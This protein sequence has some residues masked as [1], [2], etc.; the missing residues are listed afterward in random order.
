MK[1][2]KSRDWRHKEIEIVWKEIIKV[3]V[4]PFIRGKGKIRWRN[5][6]ICKGKKRFV[7]RV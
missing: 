4:V 7:K 6:S 2:E 1:V 3:N 5:I